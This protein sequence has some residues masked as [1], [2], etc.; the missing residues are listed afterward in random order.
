MD[1]YH[2]LNFNTGQKKT[3]RGRSVLLALLPFWDP[4]IPPMGISCLHGFLEKQGFHVTKADAN[5][6]K[7]FTEIQHRYFELLKQY[8][9]EELRSN[10]YNIGK[11]ILRNHMM[12]HTRYEDKQEYLQL[13][14]LLVLKNFFFEID[15]NRAA[16]LS[17][18]L[19]KFYAQLKKYWLGLLQEVQPE[20]VGISIFSGTLPASLYAFKLTKEYNPGIRT[21]MGG[22]IFADQL[23]QGSPDLELLV[24][25][26]PFIDCF[27]IGE[28]ELLLLKYLQDELTPGKRVY[29]LE[30]INGI[31]PEISSLGLPDF[32][33]LDVQYYASLASYSSRS[34]PIQCS[35]CSE[36][37]QWGKY[38]RKSARLVAKELAALQHQYGSHLFVMSDSLLNPVISPLAREISRARLSLYWDGY[39]RIDKYVCDPQNTLEWRKGGF[40]RARLGVESGSQS[41][42][43]AMNK[44]ITPAR[45][46]QAIKNLAQAG[47][48][49]TTYWIIGYPGETEADFQQTM[50]L[51]EELKNDIY[52]AE[53]NTFRYYTNGQVNSP[54]W[55]GK[56]KRLYPEAFDHL[57]LFPPRVADMAPS[58]E[59]TYQRLNRV[60][61]HCCRLRIPN[62]YSLHDIYLA[63]ERWEKL[64]PNAV[65]SLLKLKDSDI[66]NNETRQV[67]NFFPAQDTQKVEGDWGF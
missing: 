40:Y 22:G 54:Q 35:F 49:T 38:R 66:L 64:H 42:L 34:C 15:N 32:S 52:E 41:V 20:V 33:G 3:T 4:L 1:N 5:I 39:L 58:R 30:D 37:V 50:A 25:K 14:K 60:H 59:E 61:Q 67:E 62:P 63:D 53:F 11:E 17:Q 6:E 43:D 21:V 45:I 8:I 2:P 12:A 51:I 36:T 9:P 31:T 27:I 16:R 18:I 46:K 24:E 55:A 47:I 29:T 26:S 13:V 23:A 10:F 28:G 56:S 57:L 44:K 19:D 65:P 48:K 7:P